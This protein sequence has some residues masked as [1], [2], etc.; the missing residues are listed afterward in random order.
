[1]KTSRVTGPFCE[2]AAITMSMTNA[3]AEELLYYSSIG[4]LSE[5]QLDT[6]LSSA[7]KYS[8]Q[9]SK[10]QTSIRISRE[11]SKEKTNVQDTMAYLARGDYFH[12]QTF[13]VS[14]AFQANK[15][16]VQNLFYSSFLALEIFLEIS[17]NPR[18]SSMRRFT[19][20]F[21][22]LFDYFIVYYQFHKDLCFRAGDISSVGK[23]REEV[24]REL[25]RLL[26]ACRKSIIL[27]QVSLGELRT[28]YGLTGAS[29]ESKTELLIVSK[30][31]VAFYESFLE[32]ARELE[33]I[34][35]AEDWKDVFQLDGN[36]EE[37]SRELRR[38]LIDFV[39]TSP[40]P[41]NVAAFV[42][43]MRGKGAFYFVSD[44]M[45]PTE[46]SVFYAKLVKQKI[47]RSVTRIPL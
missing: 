22:T 13:S 18:I 11:L 5:Q 38:M 24:R 32:H 39:R 29:T 45:S 43:G 30:T 2:R 17:H 14:A 25:F 19:K 1:M 7:L 31:F 36:N 46:L 44:I 10:E 8:R 40:R 42:S 9:R 41:G 6:E 37:I 26:E 34:M 35:L 16:V 21:L 3:R 27:T 33:R 4:S 15:C 12:V 23:R 28:R 20:R 47:F